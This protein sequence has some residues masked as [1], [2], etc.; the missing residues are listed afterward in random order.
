MWKTKKDVDRP[1]R[2]TSALFVFFF[3]NVSAMKQ[4]YTFSNN[5][6]FFYLFSNK[7]LFRD[8]NQSENAQHFILEK[9]NHNQIQLCNHIPSANLLQLIYFFGRHLSTGRCSFVLR[10]SPLFF[11]S[12]HLLHLQQNGLLIVLSR[13]PYS[14]NH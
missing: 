9:S 7:K 6:N 4:C 13:T 12:M 8:S 3:S 2:S 5:N 1:G 10:N 11:S 14:T